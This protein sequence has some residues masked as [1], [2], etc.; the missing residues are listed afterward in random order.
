MTQK[1][2]FTDFVDSDWEEQCW[3]EKYAALKNYD[4]KEKNHFEDIDFAEASYEYTDMLC[5]N[6]KKIEDL[7]TNICH[8]FSEDVDID[9]KDDIEVIY[10]NLTLAFSE[11]AKL[12]FR[13]FDIKTRI[14]ILEK[15]QKRRIK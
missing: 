7:K 3:E 10:R 15:L 9:H 2:D 8:I 4:R 6:Q 12:R 14:L 5:T 1:F 11:I 13:N